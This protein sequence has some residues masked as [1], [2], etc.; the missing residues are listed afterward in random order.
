MLNYS[1]EYLGKKLNDLNYE[2]INIYFQTEKQESDNIEFKSYKKGKSIFN[3]DLE[4]IIRAICAFLNSNGGVLIWGAPQKE[5]I[6]EREVFKGYLSPVDHFINKDSLISKISDSITPLPIGIKVA[7]LQRQDRYIYVF[8]VPKSNYSPHQYK[9]KYWA[10]LDGQTK[11][12]PH[13]LVEALFKK[14]SYPNIEGYIN[15]NRF[16]N[17]SDQLQYLDIT[18]IIFNF[19]PLQNEFDL[20]Y[21]LLTGPSKFYV[22]PDLKNSGYT[23]DNHMFEKNFSNKTLYFGKPFQFKHRLI[24]D[25]EDLRDNYESQLDLVLTFGGKNSP[26]KTSSYKLLFGNTISGIYPSE[27]IQSKRENVALVDMQEEL[28]TT[29]ESLLKALIKR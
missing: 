3:K 1:K 20:T 27:L 7:I 25:F 28:G 24:I 16:G 4:G 8:E 10:R 6:E 9:D 23:M 12:A 14:I 15:L 2:D 19:S 17:L 11:P 5:F 26:L 13:Y 29:R 22:D 21:S 18:V